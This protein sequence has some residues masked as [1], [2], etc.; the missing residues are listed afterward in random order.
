MIPRLTQCPRECRCPHKSLPAVSGIR[1]LLG[2]WSQKS[3]H[4]LTALQ[5]ADAR[6]KLYTLTTVRASYAK[7]PL[8]RT[9]DTLMCRLSRDLF[10][11]QSR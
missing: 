9:D 2:P 11:L 8:S 4:P 6:S 3:A 10:L 5:A 7:K 1:L